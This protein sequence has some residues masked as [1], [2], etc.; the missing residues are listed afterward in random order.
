MK[1]LAPAL[2]E[3]LK[4]LPP[5]QP[6]KELVMPKMPLMHHDELVKLLE[7]NKNFSY[8]H[9]MSWKNPLYYGSFMPCSSFMIRESIV[10][11]GPEFSSHRENTNV[12]KPPQV[13]ERPKKDYSILKN[14]AFSFE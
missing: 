12:T 2:R 14:R 1:K 3:Y 9:P 6:E 10:S 11:L 5:L 13:K 8:H 4:N 7:E